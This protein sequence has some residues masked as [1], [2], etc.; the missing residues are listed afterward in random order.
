MP[1]TDLMIEALALHRA[2]NRPGQVAPPDHFWQLVER[3]RADLI[4]Q[5]FAILAHQADAEDVAQ[6]TLCEAFEG[7]ALLKDPRQLGAWMRQI[8]RRNA[9]DLVRRKCGDREKVRR[10]GG[11]RRA[12]LASG[13]FSCL[14]LREVIA[15]SIDSLP[16][17][18]RE[19][20]L[21]RYWE[22][23]S[24]QEI[25]SRNG[26]PLGSVKTLLYR[27]DELLEKRLKRYV[28]AATRAALAPVRGSQA[29]ELA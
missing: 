22:H 12:E 5:A 18:L 6:D 15:R 13:G 20:I 26:L 8:N 16:D 17:E 11:G 9:L 23:L 29:P 3:F 14:E 24:Y 19:V 4:N 27:A 1:T 25:A 2:G 28:D 21:L 10:A 7:L